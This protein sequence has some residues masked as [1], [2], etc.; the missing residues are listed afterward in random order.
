METTLTLVVDAANVVG[1]VPDGWWRDRLGATS[2][3]RDHLAV[4]AR[5]GLE[6]PDAGPETPRVRPAIVL[7]AESKAR[8]L[9][10]VEGVQVIDAPGEGDDEVV[11]VVGRLFAADPGRTVVVATADRGLQDRVRDLGAGVMSARAV[12]HRRR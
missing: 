12:R 8:G 2:R 5:D 10:S 9:E 6:V 1:S 11:A 4:L 3:L 7:V